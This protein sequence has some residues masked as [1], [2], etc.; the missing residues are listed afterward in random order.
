MTAKMGFREGAVSAFV[1]GAVL[2][3][4]VS[5][6][7][8]VKAQVTDSLRNTSAAR[9]TGRA[10]EVGGALWRAAR[11]KSIDGAPRARI[12]DRR[13]R[14]DG[15]HVEELVAAA[16]RARDRTRSPPG[17]DRQAHRP[18]EGPGR[19]RRRRLAR[20][21][22]GSDA[23]D[24]SR[25][26]AAQRADVAARRGRADRAPAHA[27]ARGPSADPHDPAARVDAESGREPR[28]ARAAVGVPPEEGSR[29][30][31]VGLRSRSLRGGDSRVPAAR[32][33]QE[34]RAIRRAGRRSRPPTRPGARR[35]RR[36]PPRPSPART[37][38]P[39]PTPPR[40]RRGRRRSNGNLRTSRRLRWSIRMRYRSRPNSPSRRP[41]RHPTCRSRRVPSR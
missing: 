32:R 35:S 38:R 18:G 14:A 24:D 3:A 30:R 37:R 26:A 1:F 12:R 29:G 6:D 10:A 17:G 21:G 34:A 31:A 39:S 41:R 9:M 36:R 13:R 7:P 11:D 20:R 23:D 5:F 25:R 28:I 33:R 2:F 4:L 27:R 8:R 22:D 15:L 40:R 16:P 19:R